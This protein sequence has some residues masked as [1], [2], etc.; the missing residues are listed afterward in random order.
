M[1]QTGTVFQWIGRERGQSTR[2]YHFNIVYKDANGNNVSE[3]AVVNF[4]RETGKN[5]FIWR[6]RM[7]AD[8]KLADAREIAIVEQIKEKMVPPAD[9]AETHSA[10]VRVIQYGQIEDRTVGFGKTLSDMSEEDWKHWLNQNKM[11]RATLENAQRALRESNGDHNRQAQ[12]RDALKALETPVK[13][14]AKPSSAPSES[15]AKEPAPTETQEPMQEED[16]GDEGA[17]EEE[18]EEQGEQQGG[19]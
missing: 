12:V 4:E 14:D 19:F 18:D 9:E 7:T 8:G 3:R 16:G 6:P 10:Y 5:A 1:A 13:E 15:P 2:S 17:D 11:D